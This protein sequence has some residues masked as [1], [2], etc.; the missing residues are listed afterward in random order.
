MASLCLLIFSATVQQ[1]SLNPYDLVGT[2]WQVANELHFEQEGNGSDEERDQRRRTFWTLYCFDRTCKWGIVKAYSSRIAVAKASLDTG[3]LDLDT[4]S[5][6]CSRRNAWR[7]RC[8]GEQA[9]PN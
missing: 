4:I 9:E 2:V 7:Y 6:Q 5:S 1:S 8:R 3:E